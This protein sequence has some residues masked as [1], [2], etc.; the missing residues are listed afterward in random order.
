MF[1]GTFGV[2]QERAQHSSPQVHQT[3]PKWALPA[4]CPAEANL[5]QLTSAVRKPEQQKYDCLE[6]RCVDSHCGKFARVFVV[7]V[8]VCQLQALLS[9]NILSSPDQNLAE[10]GIRGAQRR[11]IP[12]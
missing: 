5:D 4:F 2:T 12:A 11:T 6:R 8:T 1:K 3:Q 9:F 7:I 10:G